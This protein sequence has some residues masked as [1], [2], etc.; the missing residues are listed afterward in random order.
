V[1]RNARTDAPVGRTSWR[2]FG[3]AIGLTTA[4]AAAVVTLQANAVLA[5]GFAVSGQQFK[6]SAD[7]LEGTGF[8]NYG[9]VDQRADG[10]PVPVAVAGM[11]QATLRNMCQS[12]LTSLPIIGDVSLKITAGTGATPVTA[13][14][15]F[16][17]MTQMDGNAE[18]SNIEI[19]RD[20]STLDKGPSGAQGLQGLFGQQS[21]SVRITNLRQ[22]AWAS[23]AGTFRLS[24]LRMSLTPG[25]HEC[26]D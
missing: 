15:L 19:G 13:N 8:V 17:D 7:S 3:V 4:V 6:V 11:K 26:F 20:A 16:I 9:W 24:G 18:F 2:R 5:A 22:T 25:K 10:T 1:N 14:D 21:T 23:H 12:V